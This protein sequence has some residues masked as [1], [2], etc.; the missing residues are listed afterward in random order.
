MSQQHLVT[1]AYDSHTGWVRIPRTEMTGQNAEDLRSRGFTMV[2]LRRGMFGFR[3]VS[4]RRYLADAS[5]T[6]PSPV[7]IEPAATASAASTSRAIPPTVAAEAT[8]IPAS[9]PSRG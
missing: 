6:G 1:H 8:L 5:L 2:R 4:I 9:P 3:D 7:D